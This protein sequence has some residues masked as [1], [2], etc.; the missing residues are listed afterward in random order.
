LKLKFRIYVLRWQAG[1]QNFYRIPNVLWRYLEKFYVLRDVCY[2][3]RVPRRAS[4]WRA[5]ISKLA[6]SGDNAVTERRTYLMN[7]ERTCWGIHCRHDCYES[8]AQR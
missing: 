5:K 6:T 7:C 8:S 1:G 2:T 3:A 4:R